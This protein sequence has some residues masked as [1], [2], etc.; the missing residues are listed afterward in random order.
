MTPNI[1]SEGRN[2]LNVFI[3]IPSAYLVTVDDKL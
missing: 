3:A 2:A 1:R